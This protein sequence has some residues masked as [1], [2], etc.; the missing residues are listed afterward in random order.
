[1]S[2]FIFAVAVLSSTAAQAAVLTWYH[3]GIPNEIRNNGAAWLPVTVQ[4]V[5]V[6]VGWAARDWNED[7]KWWGVPGNFWI[8]RDSLDNLGITNDVWLTYHDISAFAE[9]ESLTITAEYGAKGP[10]RN[11]TQRFYYNGEPITVT[12]FRAPEPSGLAVATIA[13]LAICGWRRHVGRCG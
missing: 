10:G 13:G 4:Q 12:A 7:N 1:M 6:G 11:G 3:P 2:R 5:G 9:A 8:T